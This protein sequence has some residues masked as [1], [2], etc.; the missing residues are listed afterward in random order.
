VSTKARDE[1]IV[2]TI[3]MALDNRS[4]VLVVY[5][6]SH[7]YSEWKEL[8]RLMGYAEKEQTVLGR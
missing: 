3:Q 7:L 2:A 5:G 6:A 1:N 8:V 4:W